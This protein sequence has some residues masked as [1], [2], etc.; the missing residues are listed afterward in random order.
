M[1]TRNAKITTYHDGRWEQQTLKVICETPVTLLVNNEPWLTFMCTPVNLEA[2][3]VGFLFNEEII[4]AMD[5]V[6][7]VRICPGSDNIDIWLTR[8]VSKPAGWIRTSGCSGGE[9]S[10]RE[11]TQTRTKVV[12]LNGAVL[13]PD[14]VGALIGQLLEAQDLYRQSGGVHTSALS[15]GDD[16][17][18]TAEDIGRHNSLDKLAGRCLLE[19]IHPGRRILLTTGRISSEMMQKAGRMAAA[20]VI[21]R[22]SPTSLSVRMAHEMGITLVGY[23]RRD[24]FSIYTH[25][26]RI[27]TSQAAEINYSEA[28]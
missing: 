17:L 13:T 22:T 10:I 24:R 19:G 5:D 18:V 6:A 25:P 23:A 7:S 9:T 16:I 27:L 21:S 12:P 15:D 11:G 8:T 1:Q 20:V 3:G 28:K 26:D 4:H 2:L 14:Q